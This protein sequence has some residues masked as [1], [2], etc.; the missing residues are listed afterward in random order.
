MIS[1]ICLHCQVNYIQ[2]GTSASQQ[3]SWILT[4]EIVGPS[5]VPCGAREEISSHSDDLIR[6]FTLRLMFKGEN[7]DS[8]ERRGDERRRD[9]ARRDEARRDDTRRDETRH[10]KE[11]NH[12]AIRFT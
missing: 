4:R 10:L 9:E 3:A 11:C 6:Y 2:R 5:R 1:S 7:V 12:Y 8:Y